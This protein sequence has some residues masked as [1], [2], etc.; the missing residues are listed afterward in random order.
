MEIIFWNFLL[1]G[2]YYWDGFAAIEGYPTDAFSSCEND[3]I[4]V[5]W[6]DNDII[7]DA[8]LRYGLAKITF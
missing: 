7:Y 6:W 3:Q 1:P 8:D 5:N 2:I 4:W